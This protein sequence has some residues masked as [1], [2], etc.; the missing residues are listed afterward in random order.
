MGEKMIRE[1]ADRIREMP[2]TEMVEGGPLD[3]VIE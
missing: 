1:D 3:H 2:E